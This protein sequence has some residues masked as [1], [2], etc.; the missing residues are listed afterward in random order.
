MLHLG[1]LVDGCEEIFHYGRAVAARS[2]DYLDACLAAPIHVDMVATYGGG[3]YQ[4]HPA[5]F[6]QFFVAFGAGAYQ[7]Y[8]GIS[9]LGAVDVLAGQVFNVEKRFQ[10]ALDVGDSFVDDGF[11]IM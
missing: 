7:Q 3:G 6:Q 9:S 2:V 11:H 4:F 1:E 5:S 8:V 10:N